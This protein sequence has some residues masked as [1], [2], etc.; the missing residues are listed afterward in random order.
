MFNSVSNSTWNP[1]NLHVALLTDFLIPYNQSG[2]FAVQTLGLQPSSFSR[3]FSRESLSLE[4]SDFVHHN[5]K[6]GSNT[7]RLWRVKTHCFSGQ[8]LGQLWAASSFV[9]EA[10]SLKNRGKSVGIVWKN[11]P[12][13]VQCLRTFHCVS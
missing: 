6:S 11:F 12:Q 9:F 3:L 2:I 8:A 4:C 13:E 7:V 10:K 5:L 1:D